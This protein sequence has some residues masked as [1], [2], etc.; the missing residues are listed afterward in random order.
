M[1]EGCSETLG[2]LLSPS[3]SLIGRCYCRAK[4]V[5]PV[6]GGHLAGTIPAFVLEPKRGVG[7]M[8]H[9]I[10]YLQEDRR[11]QRIMWAI[12]EVR[13]PSKS[14]TERFKPSRT[15]GSGGGD[16]T[17]DITKAVQPSA[18]QFESLHCV[19]IFITS[20]HHNT[21]HTVSHTRPDE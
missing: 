3:L 8:P 7:I 14:S 12:N 15:P 17:P 2:R 6:T 4:P 1:E 18:L 16:N 13:P 11:G 19:I 20:N 5:S 21:V 10:N 9:F